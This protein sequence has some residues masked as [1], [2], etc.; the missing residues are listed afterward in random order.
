MQNWTHARSALVLTLLA[1]ASCQPTMD[2]RNYG[3]CDVTRNECHIYYSISSGYGRYCSKNSAPCP[4]DLPAASVRAR[5]AGARPVA[6]LASSPAPAPLA[7]R[8]AAALP[9]ARRYSA[10]DIRCTRDSQCGPGKCREGDCFYGCQSDAQCGSGDRCGVETGT[11]I[12]LPDPNPP[13]QCTRS[14]QCG[15]GSVC[16]NASCRQ[17]CSA[18]E[19]CDNLLDRCASGVCQPDRRPLGQCVLNEECPGGL[20]CLDGSCVDACSSTPDGGVCLARPT[21]PAPEPG[22][23]PLLDAGAPA[24][25]VNPAAPVESVPSLP[26]PVVSAPTEP[27][28]V[29][30]APVELVP[31]E[32]VPPFQPSA[33]PQAVSDAGTPSTL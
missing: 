8:G 18:S 32:P 28:P 30:P 10:F 19:D 27:V 9:D 14:A 15:E 21:F 16:L 13:I 1:G 25:S 26:V 7:D 31:V 23:F 11:R 17:T 5:D 20:V 3:T 24:I 29:E 12:C 4:D 6:P 22:L 33:E 2:S